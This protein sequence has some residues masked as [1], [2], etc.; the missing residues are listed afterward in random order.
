MGYR[1]YI[2]SFPKKE[3]NKI[4][5]LTKEEMYNFYDLKSDSESVFGEEE[6][7]KGVYEFGKEL[8]EFGKY[9]EFQPPKKSMKHFFKKKCLQERYSENDFYIVTKEFLAYVIGTYKERIKGYYNDMMLP[10]FDKKEDIFDRDKPSNFLNSV[11]T[12]YGSKEKYKFDFSKI[13][14]DE[15]TALYKTIEHVR[16]MRTEWTCL[17]PFDLDDG[18]DII[19]GSWKYEYG[20]FELVR[21]YKS[22]DWK[23]NVM[24]YYGY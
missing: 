21:I 10:F 12:E 18:K 14:D 20:I 19:T 13:T 1:T 16:S 2:A 23:K 3:Y 4:K 17:T 9:T 8:Y 15:Q 11:K 24:I 7:Y 5:S 22:F 6:L